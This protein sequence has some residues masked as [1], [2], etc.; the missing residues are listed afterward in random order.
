MLVAEGVRVADATCAS[1]ARAIHHAP[2]ADAC[3]EAY[4]AARL[5]LL[6]AEA[7]VDAWEDA[8]ENR[9]ACAVRDAASSLSHLVGLLRSVGATV[10]PAVE[11][12][13]RLAPVFAGTCHV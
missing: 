5:S 1:T 12:A 4:S 6:I 11:D 2:L 3:A 13:L 10:P 9:T 8:G 7:G